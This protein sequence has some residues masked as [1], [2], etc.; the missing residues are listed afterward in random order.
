LSDRGHTVD[1]EFDFVQLYNA[2]VKQ[3]G[4][5]LAQL[6][7][8]ECSYWVIDPVEAVINFHIVMRAVGP[9]QTYV[10]GVHDE[11]NA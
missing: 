5:D 6:G 4:K 3:Q 11:S 2:Y 10:Q 9:V 1:S 8:E 7:C